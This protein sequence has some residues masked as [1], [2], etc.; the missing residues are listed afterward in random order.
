[1]S[2]V[3]QKIRR[4]AGGVLR[5]L[6]AWRPKH[7]AAGL[8]G[9]PWVV[10]RVERFGFDML[11]D[12]HDPA[13]SR[14]LLLA[15]DYEPHVTSVLLD[16]LRADTRFLD[17][18]ANIGYFSLLAA[19]RCPQGRVFAV[20]PDPQNFRLFSAS[21]ALN[22]LRDHVTAV[23]TAASDEEGRATLSDLGNAEN[24]G[25]R[26]TAKTRAALE[27]RVHGP[28]PTFTEVRMTR[29]DRL[30]AGERIDVVKI[31]VEGHE[32]PALRGAE[33]L[34]RACKPA[35]LLE[36]SPGNIINIVGEPP[37]TPLN[38]LR[39]LGYRWQII[40]DDGHLSAPDDDPAALV[41]QLQKSGEHHADLLLTQ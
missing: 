22:G 29:L 15:G 40:A 4:Y 18:G 34:L 26:F 37:E 2:N 25:A 32:P 30:F 9:S 39:D 13:V 20:E 12:L 3:A 35:V 17:I 19:T 14:P 6:R 23:Q 8:G 36:F 21:I 11:L 24:R 41:Q 28:A 38:F 5:G 27:A 33:G 16:L 1:M 31:D 10:R 7:L